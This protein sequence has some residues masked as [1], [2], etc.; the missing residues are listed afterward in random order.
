MIERAVITSRSGSLH[1]DFSG[2]DQGA[3]SAVSQGPGEDRP[4]EVVSDAEMKR[5]EREN[6]VAAL[7]RTGWKVYGADGAAELLGIRPTTLASRITRMGLTKD[8]WRLLSTRHLPS[9]FGPTR[10]LWVSVFVGAVDKR[11]GSRSLA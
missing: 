10:I 7:E 4:V 5:R 2:D 3:I 6:L 1:L 11:L 8:H 9:A